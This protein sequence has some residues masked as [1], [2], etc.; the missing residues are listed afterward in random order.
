MGDSWHETAPRGARSIRMDVHAGV[1]I[2]KP[3]R[4]SRP[5]RV[6]IAVRTTPPWQA[7]DPAQHGEV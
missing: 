5:D 6:V 1:N 3:D 7:G 2:V 4:L